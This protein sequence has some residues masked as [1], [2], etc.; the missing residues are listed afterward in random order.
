MG[1]IPYELSKNND[2]FHLS[3]GMAEILSVGLSDQYDSFL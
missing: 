3:V 1:M 2:F